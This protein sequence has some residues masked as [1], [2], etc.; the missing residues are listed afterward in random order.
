M[1]TNLQTFFDIPIFQLSNQPLLRRHIKS[2]P[3]KTSYINTKFKVLKFILFH[4]YNKWFIYCSKTFTA[5]NI[6]PG[7]S[8]RINSL[9]G[10]GPSTFQGFSDNFPLPLLYKNRSGPS[11][12]GSLYF[13]SANKPS[14]GVLNSL[15][16]R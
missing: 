8:W 14:F 1:R 3:I 11:S 10:L 7:S 15:G 12:F 2:H 4:F 5:R 6:K 13:F 9:A 16:D